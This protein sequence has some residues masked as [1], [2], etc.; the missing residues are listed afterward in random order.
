[1]NTQKLTPLICTY[2]LRTERSTIQAADW[3]AQWSAHNAAEQSAY[4]ATNG[5]PNWTA[6]HAA[7]WTANDA[8]Y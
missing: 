5:S 7:Q 8:T 4:D 3:T 6:N 1:M 2:Y